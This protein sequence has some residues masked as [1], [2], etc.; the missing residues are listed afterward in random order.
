MDIN[1]S[2]APSDETMSFQEVQSFFVA[3]QWGFG[4]VFEERQDLFAVREM[5][6]GELA[7][8][9]RMDQDFAVHKARLQ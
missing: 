4:Q 1:P 2:Q 6:A 9:V 7:D 3:C 5:A 8:D